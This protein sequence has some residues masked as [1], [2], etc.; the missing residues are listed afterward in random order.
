VTFPVNVSIEAARSAS[1]IGAC[2]PESE[3]RN[4]IVDV[5]STVTSKTPRRGHT[6]DVP[7]RTDN[8][9]VDEMK[10]AGNETSRSCERSERRRRSRR[11]RRRR[12][13]TTNV[14]ER[15]RPK[16]GEGSERRT[17]QRP[18]E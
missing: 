12:Q 13:P 17:R 9:C 6:E 8:R 18:P 16:G 3:L 2:R 14:S 5:P 1:F 10:R 7:E 15:R 11:L 4:R